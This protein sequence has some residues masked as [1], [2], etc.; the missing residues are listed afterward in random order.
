MGGNVQWLNVQ[1]SEVKN[2]KKLF[3]DYKSLDSPVL[4]EVVNP[5]ETSFSNFTSPIKMAI[6]EAS[7]NLRVDFTRNLLLILN[8]IIR[9]FSKM[10]LH[11][12]CRDYRESRSSANGI[13]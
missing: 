8:L 10:S 1:L 3:P 4:Q 9:R 2:T 11:K 5:V 13:P 6:V 12:M 7:I